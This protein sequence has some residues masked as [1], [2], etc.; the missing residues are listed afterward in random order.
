MNPRNVEEVLTDF[1]GRRAGTIKALT[2]DVELFYKLCDPSHPSLSLY[3]LPNQQWEVNP[4]P[5]SPPSSELPEPRSSINLVRDA[6][7]KEEWLS[8][9]ALY[10]DAWL[11]ALASYFSAKCK[12]VQADRNRL[13]KKISDMPSISELIMGGTTKKRAKAKYGSLPDEILGRYYTK[14]ILYIRLRYF[15]DII[16]IAFTL[17]PVTI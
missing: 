6:T 13:F 9:V 16:M 10:S 14:R 7:S 1:K 2:K 17:C 3:G 15:S 12:F 8:M 4:S 11:H 5:P